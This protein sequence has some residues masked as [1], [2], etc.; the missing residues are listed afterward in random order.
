M[1]QL[2]TSR[3]DRAVTWAKARPGNGFDREH[4]APRASMIMQVTNGLLILRTLITDRR[5]LAGVN[6]SEQIFSSSVMR[7]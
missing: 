4:K 7:T 3:C 5:D 6:E 2:A 1:R